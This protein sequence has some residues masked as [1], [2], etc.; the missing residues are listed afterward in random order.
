MWKYIL[1]LGIIGA[2][3]I[4]CV[5][6]DFIQDPVITVEPRIEISPNEFATQVGEDVQYTA[7]YFDETGDSVSGTVFVWQSSDPNI[8]SIDANGNAMSLQV[9]QTRIFA[10]AQG[11]SSDSA[12]LT[13]V[14][15]IDQVARVVVT[16]GNA[17]L[18]PGETIQLSAVSNNING[19]PLSGR[20]FTWLSSNV[21]IVDI[22]SAGLATALMPGIAEI[23]ATTEGINS[24]PVTIEVFSQSRSGTFMGSGP[25]DVNG[26]VTINQDT[27]DSL[28]LEFGEDF[29]AS[30]G[31]GLGVYL[32][33]TNVVN[34]GSLDLGRLQSNSGAQT[35]NI[36]GGVKINTY[37]WVIIH[38]VPFNVRF[39]SASLR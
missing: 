24:S 39:G 23:T 8:A 7:T 20:I 16:P 2:G 11:I 34:S 17:Q 35:Y 10:E 30:S 37:D 4:R 3:F 36:P 26:T 5:G 13:I 1:F 18:N 38:C 32:S 15:N 12:L 22:N 29:S 21:S 25:Y 19:D 6:T 31:P 28:V 9:G 14:N 27:D 33:T